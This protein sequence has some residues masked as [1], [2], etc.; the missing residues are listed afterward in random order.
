GCTGT[1]SGPRCETELHQLPPECHVDVSCQAGCSAQARSHMQCSQPK[2][3]L[4]ADVNASSRVP[5]LKEAVEANMP[6]VILPAGAEGP[7]VLK[8]VQDMSASGKL[9]LQNTSNLGGKSVAC[10]GTAAQAA[11]AASLTMD[12][13]VKGSAKVHGSCSGNEG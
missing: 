3:V 8:A 6:K 11:A 13:S 4:A 7:I 5:I 10:A 9:I 2:V 1:I 12:V